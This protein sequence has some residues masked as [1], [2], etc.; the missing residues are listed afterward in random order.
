MTKQTK[1]NFIELIKG[2]NENGEL[3][4]EIFVTR[5]FIPFPELMELTKRLEALKDKS[6]MEAMQEM[7]KIVADLYKG[8]FTVEELMNGLHAPEAVETLQEQIQFVS[9]GYVS[10]EHQKQLKEILK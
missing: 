5:K 7:F 2:E 3:E 10:E 8:K 1:V 4:T 9:E 6:E